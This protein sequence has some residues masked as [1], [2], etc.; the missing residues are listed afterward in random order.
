MLK[1]AA[2]I[3]RF[4]SQNETPIYYFNTT[5]FNLLGADEWIGGLK[6]VNTID[7]FDGLHR[8]ALVPSG[9]QSR[10]PAG[11]EAANNYLLGHPAVA[12]FVRPGGKALF[13]MFDEQT[14][15]L[16]EKLGLQVCLP[17]AA[18]RRRLDSKIVTT[19]LADRAGVASVPNVL[20]GVESYEELRR[21][22]RALGEDLVVQAPYGD[23]GA[24]TYFISDERDF[25]PHAEL[26]AAQPL[27][28]V[29][30]RIRCR[31]MTIEGCVTRHG[32]LVGPLQ[33]ELVGFAELTPYGGGWC[34]N[35]VFAAGESTLL[36]A[37]VRRQAQ[38]ATIAIGGELSRV[39]YRGCFGLD[40]L[41]DQDTG[42]LYLGEMNPRVTGA[43]PMT[44]QAA[45]EAH[46][47]P[48][49]LLHLLEWSDAQYEFDV[50]A[51]NRRWLLAEQIANWSQMILEHVGDAA[52]VVEEAP[53]TGLWRM[54]GDGAVEFVRRSF[55]PQAA[56]REGEALFLR[57]INLGQPQTRGASLGRIVARG[58]LMTD[59]YRLN[60]RAL[61]WIRG[62]RAQFRARPVAP[63]LAGAQNASNGPGTTE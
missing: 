43:S 4:F 10:R 49:L 5:P 61:A 59:E 58:R 56:E 16:A 29:M 62:I 32:T 41:L 27:V 21:V 52:E 42:A 60:E 53:P 23:S 15:S 14:E 34:G 57:T 30:K 55:D 19:Q 13:L 20:A 3:R 54:K 9:A 18:L 38:R 6:F 45:L 51:F 1:T 35:E 26:I 50:E 7:C 24:T 40:F 47:V 2:D 25:R 11:F 39:G 22:A 8:N 44:S 48:L 17:P 37:D 31:Q 33:T 63:N 46:T 12:D 36:D 28:K